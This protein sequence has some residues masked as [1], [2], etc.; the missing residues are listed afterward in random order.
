M[1]FYWVLKPRG[2]DV[3]AY[4]DWTAHT[5]YMSASFQPLF[6]S[7]RLHFD[8]LDPMFYVHCPSKTDQDDKT[9]RIVVLVPIPLGFDASVPVNMIRSAIFK[10]MSMKPDDI[11][12]EE[13]I[14]PKMWSERLDLYRGSILGPAHSWLQMGPL[15]PKFN[16]APGVYRVGAGTHPGTGIPCCLHSGK[17]VAEEIMM[18]E[19]S[20][21]DNVRQSNTFTKASWFLS[22]T[23][24]Q[25]I[26]DL[27]AFF[28]LLDDLVDEAPGGAAGLILAE[29]YID[30]IISRLT[31]MDPGLARVHALNI[32]THIWLEFLSGLRFDA[33]T[34]DGSV[35]LPRYAHQVAGTVG[36]A[37]MYALGLIKHLHAARVLGTGL[38]RINICRDIQ[39]D[40]K[41]NRYYISPVQKKQVLVEA[42]RL[43]DAGLNDMRDLPFRYRL[44]FTLAGKCYEAMGFGRNRIFAGCKAVVQCIYTS[45]WQYH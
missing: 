6:D 24:R 14:T 3:D 26:K 23:D 42:S 4:D 39:K 36:E 7:L 8:P 41:K 38:Q 10:R 34:S 20:V 28:R 9:L 25:K 37:V 32:P 18:R 30:L 40:Y 43:I 29:Q 1:N 35:N 27:Y 16:Y 13:V 31:P 45:V 33:E 19:Q 12:H 15:R 44:V 17:M 2:T 5:I 22:A 21:L 11:V